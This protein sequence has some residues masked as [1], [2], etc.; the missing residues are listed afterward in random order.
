MNRPAV[1]IAEMQVLEIVADELE[2]SI[3]DYPELET[4]VGPLGAAARRWFVEQ[5]ADTALWSTSQAALKA[6]RPS[7]TG[8]RWKLD[9]LTAT[10]L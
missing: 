9:G 7:W 8:C 3:G 6:A 10:R 5:E 4:A 1:R 2:A